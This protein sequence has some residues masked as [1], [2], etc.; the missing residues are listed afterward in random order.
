MLCTLPTCPFTFLEPQNSPINVSKEHKIIDKRI[1]RLQNCEGVGQ[2]PLE[3]LIGD[4]GDQI[5]FQCP[6]L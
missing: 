4:S 5:D 6:F 3:S 2:A 1:L